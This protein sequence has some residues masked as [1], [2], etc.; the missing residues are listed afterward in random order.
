[1]STATARTIM[2]T[3]T[4]TITTTITAAATASA[5]ATATANATL[6]TPT[7]P[8]LI[9]SHRLGCLPFRGPSPSVQADGARCCLLVA[10]VT[11]AAA[12]AHS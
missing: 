8:P 10:F 6:A 11:Y 9:D 1:M 4:A 12:A 2:T 7:A 5:P 3:I